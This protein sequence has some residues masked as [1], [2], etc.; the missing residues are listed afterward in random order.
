MENILVTGGAGFIGSSLVNSLVKK[1]YNVIIIDNLST[2]NKFLINK[3]AAF[4]KVDLNNK[5]KIEDIFYNN[6][7]S[8]V[9]HFAASLNVKESQQNP[10]KYILNNELNTEILVK[11]CKKY[12]VKNFI[13]SSTCSVYGSSNKKKN[14]NSKKN[15][16]ST[17]A[18]TKLAG[19]RTIKKIFFKTST[20]YAILRYYNVVGANLEDKIGELHNYDHIFKNYSRQ[21]VQNNPRYIIYGNDYNTFDGTCIRDYIHI[22]DLNK[23]HLKVLKYLEN[24]RKNLI[25]NCGNGKTY[26]VLQIYSAFNNLK[27]RS[28]LIVQKKRFGDPAVAIA[29]IKKL[30]KIFKFNPKYSKIDLIV[31]D[32]IAWEK[33]IKNN[34]FVK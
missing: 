1:N 21:F 2:G 4:F 30:K 23:I 27:K 9:F 28:I 18:K 31:R 16:L 13:F 3:R 17:Y 11:T 12:K 5:K 32:S 22:K 29:N 10:K 14:E 15:P 25:M 33:Y 26:S 8:T 34:K 7:I 6:D 20:K 19:E 24:K